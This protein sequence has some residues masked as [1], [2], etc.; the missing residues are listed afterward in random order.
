MR[1]INSEA[2]C[3]LVIDLTS[4]EKSMINIHGK[5]RN[6]ILTKEDWSFGT[7]RLQSTRCQS[8]E[9]PACYTN[10]QYSVCFRCSVQ[11]KM[12]P[13]RLKSPHMFHLGCMKH[14][15]VASV[16][17]KNKL[18]A[19]L[20]VAVCEWLIVIYGTSVVLWHKLIFFL[21]FLLFTFLIWSLYYFSFVRWC[22]PDWRGLKKKS[23]TRSCQHS[24][25]HWT[26]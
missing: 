4:L 24:S 20:I 3:L 12:E 9:N 18:I 6:R 22:W 15:S 2:D 11:F 7:T 21:K 23:E 17:I 19:V 13:E 5:K 10:G 14:P 25:K 16:C 1:V 26:T 8:K